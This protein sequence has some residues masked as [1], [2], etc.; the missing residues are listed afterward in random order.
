MT[1]IHLRDRVRAEMIGHAREETPHECCGLLVGEGTLIDECV[2]ARNVDPNPATRYEVDPA[3]H[4]AVTRR[5]R[6]TSR[7]VIGC[8][9]SHPRTPP[10]PSASD[11]AE[12]LYPGFVWMIVSLLTPGAE[13]AAYR[14][15]SDGV[16]TLSIYS[17]EEV[18]PRHLVEP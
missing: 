2:R 18:A 16:V 6:G 10:V 3:T 5:L 13:V 15:D 17:S 8:Y 1:A 9:H 12:A 11:R 14:M 7:S 4:I